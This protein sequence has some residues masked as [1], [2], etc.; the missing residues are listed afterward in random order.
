[1]SNCTDGSIGCDETHLACSWHTSPWTFPLMMTGVHWP[2][3]LYCD[4][5]W[6]KSISPHLGQHQDCDISTISDQLTRFFCLRFTLL[7][8]LGSL[9]ILTLIATF[10]SLS[11]LRYYDMSNY[12]AYTRT[13]PFLTIFDPSLLVLDCDLSSYFWMRVALAVLPREPLSWRHC[14]MSRWANLMSTYPASSLWP[15]LLFGHDNY[16]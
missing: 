13:S 2:L 15:L 11:T 5:S 12:D 7:R 1:M 4:H 9:P 10:D 6:V 3:R 14:T 16:C 8:G